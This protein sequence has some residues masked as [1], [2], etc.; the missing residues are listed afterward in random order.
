[1]KTIGNRQRPQ[2]QARA[3]GDALLTGA[4][5]S[6]S[7][8]RLAGSTFVPKG[9][10]RFKSHEA[11]NQHQS[12]CL[13]RGMALLAMKRSHDRKAQSPGNT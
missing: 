10:Y 4:L 11:A 1:M 8:A 13:A 12:D 2:I 5:F 6:E 3:S 7:I 9:V